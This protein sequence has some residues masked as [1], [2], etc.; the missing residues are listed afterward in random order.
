M[1]A[2]ASTGL[3]RQKRTVG[4]GAALLEGHRNVAAVHVAR[5]GGVLAGHIGL[6]AVRLGVRDRV[7]EVAS[8]RVN[9][10]R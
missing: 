3:H 6:P 1:P 8:N 10:L 4:R 5:D 2:Y 7:E 9:D